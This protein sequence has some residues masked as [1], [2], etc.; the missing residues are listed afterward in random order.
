M[1]LFLR[2]VAPRV[3]GE[4]SMRN[5]TRTRTRRQG[6]SDDKNSI[7]ASELQTIG[8]KDTKSPYSRMEDGQASLYSEEVSTAGWSADQQSD[9]GI[10]VE[11]GQIIRSDT[12]VVRSDT[13]VDVEKGRS[14]W[15]TSF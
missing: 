14:S 7:Q 12:V 2:H 5:R 11:H 15:R 9:H 13:L 3:F 4:T 8:S 6:T 1:R 10:V